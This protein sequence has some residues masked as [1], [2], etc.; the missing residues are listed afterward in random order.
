MHIAEGFLPPVHAAAWFA[1]ATPFVV[2]GA[3]RVVRRV[4]EEPEQRMVLGAAA[5]FTFLLSA[6]KL[7]SISGSSSHPTG[8]GLGAVLFKP[9]IMAFMCT[10]VLTFQALLLAHGGLTTLGANVVSMGVVGPWA[11]YGAY[12]LMRGRTVG[13]FTGVAVANLA[14]YV[15]TSIQLALAFPDPVSGLA[16]AMVKFLSIFAVTQVPLAIVEGLLAVLV[17]RML[18]DIAAP[19]LRALGVLRGAASGGA[20]GTDAGANRTEV[21]R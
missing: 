9:P 8:A 12:R 1:V 21:A 15:M 18:C 10:V 14:T 4:R 5:A 11:G 20:S 17:F 3:R 19:Q 16:G 6:I 2:H 7:P 13:V